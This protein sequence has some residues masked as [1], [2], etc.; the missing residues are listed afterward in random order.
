[1]LNTVYLFK[2]KYNDMKERRYYLEVY[3]LICRFYNK[4]TIKKLKNIN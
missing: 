3:S 2:S 1:M 4:Y